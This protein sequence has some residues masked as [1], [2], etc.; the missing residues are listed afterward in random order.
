MEKWAID[1]RWAKGILLMLLFLPVL[2]GCGGGAIADNLNPD[3]KAT[4][5]SYQ[6]ISQIDNPLF[7]QVHADFYEM[8]YSADYALDAYMQ[9]GSVSNQQLIDFFNTHIFH[10]QK[11][12]SLP[13]IRSGC[14]AISAKNEL[15][16]GIFGKN[17]DWGYPTNSL[18]HVP[19]LILH[20]KPASGYASISLV[21][22]LFLAGEGNDQ[23]DLLIA[24]YFPM[25][26]MNEA[27]LAVSCL[28]DP[29]ARPGLDQHKTSV[30]D[31]CITRIVLDK[32]KTVDEAIA[33]FQTYNV[34]QT[35]NHFIVADRNGNSAVIEFDNGQTKIVRSGKPWQAVTNYHL[36]GLD[37]T[38]LSHC[39]RYRTAWT[40]LTNGNGV[41][42]NADAMSLMGSIAE[43]TN[44]TAV[45]NLVTGEVKIAIV[46]NYQT[47]QTFNLSM[48]GGG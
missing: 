5:S 4:L 41:I 46:R 27:G 42:T 17:F 29:D 2:A 44:W 9:T 36:Y 40:T 23:Q 28:Y 16:H 24:P 37:P 18:N 14:A 7:S 35:P 38:D 15:G 33:L 47:I 6:L 8:T 3:Q 43:E 10:Q 25:D 12:K 34:V 20:T 21:Y 30:F 26:G 39:W 31:V 11:L 13:A 1:L 45:Y 48:L 32:A 19:I 22:I